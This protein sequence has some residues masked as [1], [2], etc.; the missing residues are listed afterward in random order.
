MLLLGV[1]TETTGTD[2]ETDYPTEVGAVLWCTERARPLHMMQMLI[3]R[4]PT[5]PLISAE[6]AR[7]S[8]LNDDARTRFGHPLCALEVTVGLM[9]A[10]YGIDAVVAHNAP[11]DRAMMAKVLSPTAGLFH[12]PWIDTYTDVPLR[13][14]LTH[15]AAD[16]GVLNPFPHCSL[17]DVLTMLKVVQQYDVPEILARA[18]SPLLECE[19]DVT[20]D[21]RE[22]PKAAGF[23]WNPEKRK[24]YWTG[25]EVDFKQQKPGWRFPVK[26]RNL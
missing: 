7:V 4:P 21:L 26:V 12:V 16:H 22:L 8:G 17:P 10:G 13:G 23:R 25:R 1:D 2:T 14:S 3:E 15:V 9:Y 24:W 5:G 11:F 18:K 19:A 6:A 20:Y